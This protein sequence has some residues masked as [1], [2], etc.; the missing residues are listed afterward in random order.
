MSNVIEQIVRLKTA[1]TDIE[2]SIEACGVDVPN[3]ELLDT[4]ASYIRQ[5]PDVILNNADNKYVSLEGKYPI[6]TN[7]IPP[8]EYVHLFRIAVSSVWSNKS[9][10][11]VLRT[12]YQK[13]DFYIDIETS[14]FPYGDDP[15]NRKI[16]TIKIYKE[17]KSSR[18]ANLYYLQTIQSSGYN[19]FD[20][21][22]KVGSWSGG[23][24]DIVNIGGTGNLIFEDKRIYL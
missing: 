15:S 21:Y 19:Y 3:S 11:F 1:K 16:N 24:Y 10:D 20:I 13:I 8:Y 18:T 17:S 5:I 7:D 6:K 2:E 4:Y 12:R 23:Y 9:V 22:L 14:E